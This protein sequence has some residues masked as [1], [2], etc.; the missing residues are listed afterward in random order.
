MYLAVCLMPQPALS[1]AI[2]SKSSILSQINQT[3]DPDY[4]I[5]MLVADIFIYFLLYLYL[6]QIMP[7]EYGISKHPLFILRPSFWK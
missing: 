1:F 5:W 6:D 4:A 2:M 3:I 7:N